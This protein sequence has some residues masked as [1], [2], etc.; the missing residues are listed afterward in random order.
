MAFG[1]TDSASKAQRLAH[2]GDIHQEAS[3]AGRT[4]SYLRLDTLFSKLFRSITS[5]DMPMMLK[6]PVAFFLNV[7]KVWEN[8]AHKP[9]IHE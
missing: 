9:R 8:N 6:R 1:I 4:S 5:C 2:E 7:V 3:A